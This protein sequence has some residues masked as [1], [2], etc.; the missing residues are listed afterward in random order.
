MRLREQEVRA[1]DWGEENEIKRGRGKDK[2][3]GVKR[4]RLREDEVRVR[5]WGE[6]N[7]IK[8]GRGK[9]KGLG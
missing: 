8:R 3:V 9:G 7:E 6:E 4:L 2:R 5:G 1:R